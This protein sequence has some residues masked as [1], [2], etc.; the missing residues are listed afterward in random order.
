MGRR[1]LC[2][3]VVVGAA[4]C[5]SEPG[6]RSGEANTLV[7]VP[8]LTLPPVTTDGAAP[9]TDVSPVP[10]TAEPVPFPT[11][12]GLVPTAD[13][14]G[15]L[16]FPALGNPGLDV[17][18]YDLAV[19]YEPATDQLSGSVGIDLVLTEDR[20]EITLDSTDPL[21]SEVAI[22]GVP[23]QFLNDSPEL[24]IELAQPMAA[25]STLRIEV[26]YAL[27]PRPSNSPVGLPN[28]WFNTPGGSYVLNEPDGARAWFPCNDHPSDKATYT[29]TIDVPQGLTGVAN[30]QLVDQRTE[31]DRDIWVWQQDDPMTTYLILLLTGD[32]ELIS[33]EG[34]GGVPLLDAVLRDDV[35]VMQPYIDLTPEM[36]VFFEGVFGPYPL[37]GYGLAFSDS[38]GGLAMETQ[39]RS[40]YSREDFADGSLG[41]QQQAFLS[42]EL[43]HQY[44]GNAVSPGRWQDIWLNESFATYGEWMWMEHA[45]FGALDDVAQQVL[46]QRPPG[47]TGLPGV[48]EMFSFNTYSGGAV[49]L[50][51]LRL[52]MGDGPFFEMMRRWAIDAFGTSRTTDEFIAFAE[53]FHGASL[54]EFFDEW[55][56]AVQPP[57]RFPGQ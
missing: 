10:T 18:H 42:H 38:F 57:G 24:R 6:V 3:L 16:L 15:D 13:G 41:Y 11:V 44:Y 51:A 54:T 32:Y 39:G 22:D 55:L 47:S 9:T 53:G 29:F 28:G 4:A 30:G 25:G 48:E 56:F 20:S 31:G 46:E 7:S 1:W 43:V 36:M 45:G 50:H 23:V 8:F 33:G 21:V 35:A 2:I 17:Q 49:V 34:P 19:R 26:V 27:D 37:D 14:A 52:T 12:P 5:S 40:L